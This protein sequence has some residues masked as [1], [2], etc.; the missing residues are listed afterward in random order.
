M[1]QALQA[2][3]VPEDNSV[4]QNKWRASYVLA[5]ETGTPHAVAHSLDD[6]VAFE[7]VLAPSQPDGPGGVAFADA[8]LTL[9]IRTKRKRRLGAAGTADQ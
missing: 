3:T 4:V 1:A 7:G 5:F 6:Q 9:Q 2:L 8:H